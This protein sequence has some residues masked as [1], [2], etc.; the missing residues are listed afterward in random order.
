MDLDPRPAKKK[1]FWRSKLKYSN[2]INLKAQPNPESDK[3]IVLDSFIKN[4]LNENYCDDEE[5]EN[6]EK[7]VEELMKGERRPSNLYKSK[8]RK[9]KKVLRKREECEGQRPR[10]VEIQKGKMKKTIEKNP[11]ELEDEPVASTSQ[12]QLKLE[13]SSSCSDHMSWDSIDGLDFSE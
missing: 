13:Y 11:L 6:E 7:Y 5:I 8:Q 3:N 10:G 4:H 9:T 2:K 1:Q 12:Q